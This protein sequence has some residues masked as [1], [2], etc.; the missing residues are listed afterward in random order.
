VLDGE[1]MFTT[2][3]PGRSLHGWG[4]GDAEIDDAAVRHDLGAALA[5]IHAVTGDRYGY[6]GGG[7]TTG[8][9]WR[10]VF[11]EMVEDLLRD[12]ATWAVELPVSVGRIRNAIE[13]HADLLE[14]VRRPALLHFDT[15]D[16]NVLATP[17]DAGHLRLTGLV[18]GERYLYGDPL[19][20]FVSAA[21][22]RRLED[23][24]GHPFLLGYAEASGVPPSLDVSERRRLTLYRLHLYLLMIV[25]MPSRGM[26]RENESGR[27]EFLG[28][29]LDEQLHEL[30]S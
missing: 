14:L 9:N 23:E 24:P 25:E 30:E 18:D 27:H 19:M 2:M 21:L 16:G 5:A 12:A 3:L 26:T 28:P 10:V 8:A 6:D 11:A 22:F 13:R 29:L 4:M 17:D 15:W 7:R 1:W 20:D